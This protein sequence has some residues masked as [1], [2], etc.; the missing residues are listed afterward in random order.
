MGSKDR[1]RRK[2]A[3]NSTA[4]NSPDAQRYQFRVFRGHYTNLVKRHERFLGNKIYAVADQ[5][6]EML[7]ECLR[8]SE[9][10]PEDERRD[11]FLFA[12]IALGSKIVSHVES[13]RV[14]I[15][16]ARYGDAA[17]LI[18]VFIGDITMLQYL[19]LFPEEAR[20]WLETSRVR[21]AVP[22]RK[23]RYSDLRRKFN[24]SAMRRRIEKAGVRPVSAE[25]YGAFSEAVHPSLWGIQHYAQQEIFQDGQYLIQ[26]AP[27]YDPL[28]AW[29][30]ALVM[31]ALLLDA[32]E[33]FL[34]WCEQTKVEWHRGLLSSFIPVQSQVVESLQKGMAIVEEAHRRFYSG[35]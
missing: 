34:A 6:L 3:G 2:K 20:E 23:G 4:S 32:I 13:I 21:Q 27:V 1:P 18:R 25:G 9:A 16:I 11:N 17:V 24:E 19:S 22:S 7:L 12:F 31:T 15:N 30:R 33:S 28:T 8:L 26:Y 5:L 29:R 14:L 10:R 35:N